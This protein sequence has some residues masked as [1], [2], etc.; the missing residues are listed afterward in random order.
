MSYL[1]SNTSINFCSLCTD[2]I[3]FIAARFCN[4]DCVSN[5]QLQRW[6]DREGNPHAL[7]VAL[8]PIKKN[9]PITFNYGD[10]YKA[11]GKQVSS[12]EL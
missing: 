6:Y 1:K 11:F 4:H 12:N 10:E 7:I 5:C 2:S 3:L 8:Q 9:E